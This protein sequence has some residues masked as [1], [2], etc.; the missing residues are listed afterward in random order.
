MI[1]AVNIGN[2]NIRAALGDGSSRQTVFYADEGPV[3]DILEAGLGPIWDKIDKCILAT[4]VPASTEAVIASLEQKIKKPVLR[5]DI[6][7]CGNLRTDRY[8]GLLG[9]D[10]V[11]CCYSALQKYTPPFVVIDFGTATTVNVVNAE[12]EFLGG[13]IMAGLQTGLTALSKNTAQLPQIKW[14]G[15]DIK[16]IGTNTAENLLSGAVI[17]LACAVEGFIERIQ[18]VR[19]SDRLKVV[20]TGGHAPVILPHCR[21]EYAHEPALLLEGLLSLGGNL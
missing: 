12:G 15:G 9:E 16:L 21:F 13:A 20:V 14:T 11:V 5:I 1:L 17:G 2:T 19:T 8:E 4:V 18:P 10:R 7:N 3:V 6:R